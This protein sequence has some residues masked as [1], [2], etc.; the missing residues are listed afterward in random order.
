[1]T[2]TSIRIRW[3]PLLVGTVVLLCGVAIAVALML[4][5][6][7]P[8][9]LPAA[10]VVPA[11]VA[12]SPTPAPAATVWPAPAAAPAPAAPAFNWNTLPIETRVGR[13]PAGPALVRTSLPELKQCITD[14]PHVPGAPM[15]MVKVL[16]GLVSTA[17]GLQVE[18]VEITDGNVS[19]PAARSCIRAAL[20]GKQVPG[21]RPPL[22]TRKRVADRLLLPVPPPPGEAPRPLPE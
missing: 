16:L 22:G 2:R 17:G 12:A 15:P 10:A 6:P 8:E 5:T 7:A 1:L 14:W 20:L 3:L 9:P 11:P 13:L 4:P 19:D 21:P 18:D